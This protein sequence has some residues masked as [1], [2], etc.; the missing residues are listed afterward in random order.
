MRAARHGEPAAT[1]G[2]PQLIADW[3]A[4][5]QGRQRR[6]DLTAETLSDPSAP[7]RLFSADGD[8]SAR[9]GARWSPEGGHWTFTFRGGAAVEVVGLMHP[10]RDDVGCGPALVRASVRGEQLTFTP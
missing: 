2:V 5:E 9:F 10:T 7:P 4:P 6:E 3:A 1:G 8:V